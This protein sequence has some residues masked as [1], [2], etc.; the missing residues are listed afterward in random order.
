MKTTQRRKTL[1]MLLKDKKRST[2]R[3][4]EVNNLKSLAKEASQRAI[5]IAKERK[6]SITYL[7]DNQIIEESSEG[8]IT[9]IKTLDNLKITKVRKGEKFKIS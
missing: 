5:K 9:V 8:V 7:K 6:V 4:K 3:L 1:K 2:K